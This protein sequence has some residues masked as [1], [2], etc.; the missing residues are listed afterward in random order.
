MLGSPYQYTKMIDSMH[1]SPPYTGWLNYYQEMG[2]YL[3]SLAPP[4]KVVHSINAAETPPDYD[5]GSQEAGY[6]VGWS[7]GFGVRDGFGSQGLSVKDYLN[8]NIDCDTLPNP[9]DPSASNWHPMFKKYN[10]Y[11]LPLELQPIALS[12]PDDTNCTNGCSVSTYSGD[13]PTF[14]YSFA[15]SV[16]GSD[17]EIYWRDLS[18]AYD[19]NN[20]CHFTT[21]L[22]PFA[23]SQ[24][25][26]SITLGG[27]VPDF[28]HLLNFFQASG[29]GNNPACG[30]NMPQTGSTGDCD[31]A[32]NINSA[33]GQH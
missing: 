27:Q 1:A 10:T 28:T 29:Q 22:P 30:T 5:Y 20:Y 15:T 17:F 26:T 19:V 6:A 14:L 7:N 13:L 12:Y 4:V 16:G 21:M 9:P 11:G 24:T 25:G 33:H 8:C 31:Y 3:Q 2:N 32:I 18:L 23:C